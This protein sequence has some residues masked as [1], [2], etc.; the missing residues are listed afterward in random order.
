MKHRFRPI[1]Y[2][3][4]MVCKMGNHQLSTRRLSVRALARQG[5]KI[6][7]PVR[8]FC[9][10]TSA[11]TAVEYAVMLALILCA[12]LVSISLVG[13]NTKQLWTSN[14]TTLQGVGFGS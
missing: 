9:Q 8:R 1:L 3:Q 7:G 14:N 6:R 2:P 11:A 10:E 5:W 13:A 4:P 12:V